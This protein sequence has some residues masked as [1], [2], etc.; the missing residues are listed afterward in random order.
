[1]HSSIAHW[2]LI[3]WKEAGG[4]GG[5]GEKLMAF[6]PHLVS[7]HSSIVHWNLIS[8]KI[9]IVPPWLLQALS[10]SAHDPQIHASQLGCLHL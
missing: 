4:E 10:A 9:R 5:R 6:L 3:A 7:P 8:V 2:N 1:M